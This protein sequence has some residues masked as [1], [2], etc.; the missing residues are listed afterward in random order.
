MTLLSRIV[1][2]EISGRRDLMKIARA[3]KYAIMCAEAVPWR[4]HRSLVADALVKRSGRFT[5]SRRE[6]GQP[7][8]AYAISP[9]E[10]RKDRLSGYDSNQEKS[11]GAKPSTIV[12]QGPGLRRRGRRRSS[13]PIGHPCP[14]L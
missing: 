10:R 13:C 1:R 4:C 9:D 6:E 8:Y 3:K 11:R 5:H 14:L 12:S 7:P 2:I